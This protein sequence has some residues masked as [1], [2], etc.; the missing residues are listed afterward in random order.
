MTNSTHLY[1]Q[2]FDFLRQYSR[3]RDL[4]HLKA[5]AWMVSALLCSGQLSLAAWEPYVP[6]RATKAQSV[7][8]RWQRFL[9][10][11]R[12]SVTALYVPL[13]LVALSGW[14]GQ[15][16]Y[17]AL[18]TTVLWDRYCMIHL[19][20]ICCGRAVPLLWRVLE[21]G[22]ATVAFSEYQGMLRKARWLLRQYPDV[23]LLADRGFANHQLMGWL[24]SSQWHYCLRLPCDVLLHGSR[25]Y[26]TTVGSL[27]P[28]LGEA[29]FSRNVGLWG[30]GEHRANLVL[31][32][33]KGAKDSWAVV[34]DEP[35]TLQTLW[36]YALRFRVEEL[37]LDSKSGAFELEESRL[38]SAAALERLYLVAA[39]A[40][41]YATTQGMAVQVAGFRQQVDPH[42]R[43]GISYLK[44]GLRWLQGVFHKGRELLTPV[45]LLPKDP[46]PVFASKRAERDFYDQIW[47]SRIRSLTCQP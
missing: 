37:F 38:R 20:V 43:R 4:R 40:L 41:L 22:S 32:T 13:V 27:Y 1:G 33:V 7:E 39:I 42:W 19:S 16:V 23:M 34:T 12:V 17:I 9:V 21:H 29:R 45:P 18:D 46:Q 15:R 26:P 2:L 25:R 36:Q 5:L 14:Q 3:A 8:R 47:F 6:S 30:D 10:N 24:R 28:P 11:V 44:M 31:A 35:P